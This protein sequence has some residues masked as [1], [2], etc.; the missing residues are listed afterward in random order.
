MFCH[1]LSFLRIFRIY[2]SH[3]LLLFKRL[4]IILLDI[5][6]SPLLHNH[7]FNI[8]LHL[9]DANLSLNEKTRSRPKSPQQDR[10]NKY[11]QRQSS[12]IKR[13]KVFL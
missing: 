10:K 1:T 2:D 4:E 9:R 13:Y 7:D 12:N 6:L 11:R 5:Y 3:R 8:T